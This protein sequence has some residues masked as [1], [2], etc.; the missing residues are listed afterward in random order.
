MWDRTIILNEAGS[1]AVHKKFALEVLP[2][3]SRAYTITE[4]N[5]ASN[6]DRVTA[7]IF[8]RHHLHDD[9]KKE[10][11]TV[12]DPFTSWNC[13]K[14]RFDHLKLVIL[15][16]AQNDWLNLRLQDF[17]SVAAYNSALFNITLTLK[18]CG[19]D[20]TDEQMLEKTFT[21]FHAS[22]VLLQQQ[23]RERKFTEYSELI[24]CLLIAE[25]N[26]DLLL[27]NL[28][29]RPVGSTAV[30]EVHATTSFG[31][32][33][34]HGNKG[35]RGY[36]KG[37]Q[38][39]GHKNERVKGTRYQLYQRPL[40]IAEPK[41][42]KQE[43]GKGSSS[44]PPQKNICYRCGLTNHWQRIFRTPEHF[45]KLYQASLKRPAENIE[46]NLIEASAPS[47]SNT[48]LDVSDYLVGPEG[49]EPSQFSFDEL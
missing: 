20:V 26:N 24:S 37:N 36:G 4:G 31:R 9:L 40:K 29:A 41:E 43:K 21:T 46:I 27:R 15:P 8:L 19:E 16:K 11:L 49:G 5:N 17:R 32:G 47:T 23:Y 12:K 14:K 39:G 38:R 22:N 28:E 33:N 48:H 45:L 13:L 2:V 42:P 25:Q 34:N 35:K 18:L 30:T 10:Y 6:Q 44:Q 7:L 1:S 3:G